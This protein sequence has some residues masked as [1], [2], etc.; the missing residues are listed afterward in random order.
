MVRVGSSLNN[1]LIARGYYDHLVDIGAQLLGHDAVHTTTVR[2]HGLIG[3]VRL[4]SAS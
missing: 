4:V 3:P 2:P 1:R